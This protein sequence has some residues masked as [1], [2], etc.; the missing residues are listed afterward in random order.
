M[1]YGL[2]AA[3]SSRMCVWYIREFHGRDPTR[4][5]R[6]FYTLLWPVTF[7][8]NTLVGMLAVEATI[9][10]GAAAAFFFWNHVQNAFGPS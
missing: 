7:V 3:A 9:V 1:F 5:E 8:S 2:M 4:Y 6:G 10:G